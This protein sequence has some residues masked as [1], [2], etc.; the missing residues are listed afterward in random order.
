MCEEQIEHTHR[1]HQV[2]VC[3]YVVSYSLGEEYHVSASQG[4][5]FCFLLAA[6]HGFE[7]VRLFF[8]FFFPF[9]KRRQVNDEPIR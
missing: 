4:C 7:R 3:V 1:A 2:C 9:Q 8:F 6:V 5:F